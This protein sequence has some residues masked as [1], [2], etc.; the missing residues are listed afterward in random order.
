MEYNNYLQVVLNI[1][2]ICIFSTYLLA[3]VVE[4]FC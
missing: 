2:S 4:I 3:L 1:T